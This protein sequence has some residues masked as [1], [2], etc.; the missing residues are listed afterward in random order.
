MKK[1]SKTEEE[2]V[3]EFIT[4]HKDSF[5]SL[6]SVPR[7]AICK[8]NNEMVPY[9]YSDRVL[10][11]RRIE[12]EVEEVLSKQENMAL[13]IYCLQNN[14]DKHSLRIITGGNLYAFDK[15]KKS[16]SYR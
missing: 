12:S 9:E 4:L 14:I 2:K 11:Y 15:M 7:V 10:R 3:K 1:E 5:L 13:A 8:V 16:Y 6:L